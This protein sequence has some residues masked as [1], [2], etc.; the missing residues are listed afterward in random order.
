VCDKKQN[1]NPMSKFFDIEGSYYKYCAKVIIEIKNVF[2]GP[3]RVFFLN[4]SASYFFANYGK[5]IS[6]EELKASLSYYESKNYSNF[7][8]NKFYNIFSKIKLQHE[9]YSFFFNEPPCSK[10][11]I[12]I[13]VKPLSNRYPFAKITK[14]YEIELNIK[15]AVLF[16][17]LN[18]GNQL[19]TFSDVVVNSGL[20]DVEVFG[21]AFNTRL[22]NYGSMFPELE[23]KAGCIGTAETIFKDIIDK[24]L[25]VKGILV[26]PPSSAA[27]HDLSCTSLAV[28]IEMIKSGTLEPINIVLAISHKKVIFVTKNNLHLHIKKRVEIKT[29]YVLRTDEKKYHLE[30][31]EL[32]SHWYEY[33]F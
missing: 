32:S 8:F 17:V 6:S 29:A 1:D 25:K 21:S 20:Y 4:I 26:S 11:A 9:T 14:I 16:D 10:N 18:P 5:E 22:P 33:Y 28:I 23:K 31:H 13:T 15:Y 27:L 7:D 30:P 2:T 24:K 3:E 12:K 19:T